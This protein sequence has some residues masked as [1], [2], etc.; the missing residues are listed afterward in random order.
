MQR[1]DCRIVR[2][3]EN[4]E[5]SLLLVNLIIFI[6]NIYKVMFFI[7]GQKLVLK[8]KMFNR[9]VGENFKE[10]VKDFILIIDY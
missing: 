4:W 8:K 6:S 5:I 10:E 7:N 2:V 3:G 1:M 9:I